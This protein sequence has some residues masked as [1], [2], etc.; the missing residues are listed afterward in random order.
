MKNFKKTDMNKFDIK[1]GVLQV[2]NDGDIVGFQLIEY[3]LNF[4]GAETGG[5][6]D[7]KIMKDGRQIVI[8]GDGWIPG[9]TDIA[10]W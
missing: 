9:G 8:D 6:L 5:I 10:N 7:T 4:F 1:R 2:V 3:K